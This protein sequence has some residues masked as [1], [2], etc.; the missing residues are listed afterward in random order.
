L[1]KAMLKNPPYLRHVS[2]HTLISI[3]PESLGY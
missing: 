3:A 2:P 1:I